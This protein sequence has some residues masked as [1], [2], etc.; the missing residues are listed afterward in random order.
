M[1]DALRRKEKRAAATA[2]DWHKLLF[3]NDICR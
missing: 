3:L 1:D 2:G